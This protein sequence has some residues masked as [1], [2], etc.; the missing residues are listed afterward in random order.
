[1][2]ID[3]AVGPFAQR[4]ADEAFGLAVGLRAIGFG[5]CMLQ[6]ERLADAAEGFGTKRRPV[7]GQNLSKRNAKARVVGTGGAQKGERAGLSLIGMHLREA[8]PR[9]IVDGNKQS[10]KA[11]VM[12]V[13]LRAAGD[14]MANAFDTPQ[15][16]GVDVEKIARAFV[17][18]AHN[19][20]NGIEGAKPRQAGAREHPAHRGARYLERLGNARTDQAFFA[21][22]DNDQ[23]R[24]GCNRP[25]TATRTRG[26]IE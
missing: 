14:A 9:V 18:I 12:R 11:R 13:A 1:M 2:M 17:L 7:I 21:Q 3:E 6:A 26:A 15:L 20:D 5:K 25:W 23:S 16:F 19:R 8:D 4:R 22:F 10:F 24:P